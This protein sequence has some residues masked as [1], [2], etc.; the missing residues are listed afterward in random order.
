MEELEAEPLELQPPELVESI[1]LPRHPFSLPPGIVRVMAEE[2]TR[3]P[4]LESFLGT[5]PGMIYR[6]RLAP[7]FDTEFLS[8]ETGSVAGY[9]AS[10]FVGAE[11]ERRWRDLIHPDDREGVLQTM[12]DVP[13]DGTIAEVEYRVRR[14][15]GS[16]AWIL[17]R[18]RKIVA[19]DGTPWLH[20]ASV[21][22]TTGRGSAWSWRR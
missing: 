13:A 15:D 19:P 14:A 3:S 20:G 12:L 9:P 8:E 5:V 16:L 11:P 1:R 18:A 6:T 4:E 22:S 17:S 21:T 10:E 7:P 2:P